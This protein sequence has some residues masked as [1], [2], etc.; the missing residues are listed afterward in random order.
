MKNSKGRVCKGHII[1]AQT[2]RLEVNMN[3]LYLY[4]NT[5]ERNKIRYLNCAQ[6]S[7]DKVMNFVF[8]KRA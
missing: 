6:L 1:N 8:H 4:L 3:I 2:A 5:D 7:W